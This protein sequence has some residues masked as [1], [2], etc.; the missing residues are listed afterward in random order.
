MGTAGCLLTGAPVLIAVYLFYVMALCGEG[1]DCP[2]WSRTTAATVL[3]QASWLVPVA[4][5][6]YA[7]AERL[8]TR[9]LRLIPILL[10]FAF[11]GFCLL[12]FLFFR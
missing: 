2:S 6:L 12:A 3:F 4:G 11:G 7:I 10:L 8:V 5:S 1:G 9:P